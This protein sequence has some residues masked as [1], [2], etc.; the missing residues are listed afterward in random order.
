ME[1]VV[2]AGCINHAAAIY[3]SAFSSID[4]SQKVNAAMPLA[5]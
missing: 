5:P 1:R 2:A 3:R 4:T